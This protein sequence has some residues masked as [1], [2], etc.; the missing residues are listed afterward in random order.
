MNIRF[1]YNRWEHHSAHSGYNTMVP[2]K[3]IEERGSATFGVKGL[4]LAL[5]LL[6]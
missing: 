3:K 6:I 4:T 5:I 1:I 2:L